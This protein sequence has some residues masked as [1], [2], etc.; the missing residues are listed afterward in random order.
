MDQIKRQGDLVIARIGYNIE[1]LKAAGLV[2][3]AT[4]GSIEGVGKVIHI[5]EGRNHFHCIDGDVEVLEAT[6]SEEFVDGNKG[7]TAWV[8]NVKSDEANL[9]H[10]DSGGV[11]TEDHKDVKVTKGTHRVTTQRQA[12]PSTVPVRVID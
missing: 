3:E 9:R 10:V 12:D 5:G 4:K 2:K 1:A 8:L 7:I 11:A 6:N